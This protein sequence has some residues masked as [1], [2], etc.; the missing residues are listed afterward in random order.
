MHTGTRT[1]ARIVTGLMA[2][3][4]VVGL[5]PASLLAGCSSAPS[6]DA[7]PADAPETQAISVVDQTG[8]TVTLDKPAERV[9][10]LTASSA[11]IVYALGAGAS[12][13]GRGEYCDWPIEVLDIPVVQSGADTNIE[14][15]I[16][17]QPDLVIMTTMAQNP[18]QVAQ[19]ND[20]GIAVYSSDATDIAQ[21]Y[22][23]IEQIGTLFGRDA[24]ALVIVDGMKAT[25]EQLGSEEVFGTVY[26]E[27]SPLEY[28][29]WAAGRGTFM[30][31]IGEL[32]GLRNIFVDV[33]GWAEV[34]E[35]QVLER[36]PDYIVTV[37]MYFGEGL[38]PDAEV[39][40][41]PSWQDVTAVQNGAVLNLGNNEL[42]RPGPRLADGAI[43]LYD[44]VVAHPL[45]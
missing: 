41:R 37:G 15:I 13:V 26:F 21:T 35:E 14:Q 19:L 36:N 30:N 3:L 32:M 22:E 18:D 27:V 9:V 16:A 40:A 11:E 24:E 12:V 8:T 45:L 4:L 38:T 42:A 17:L 1:K 5:L 33:E 25:F 44:F 43:A 31:E 28:G 34:S 23:S 10:A 7:P 20:A 39:L 29:L 2:L 6:S